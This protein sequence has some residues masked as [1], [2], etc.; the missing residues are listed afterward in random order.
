MQS[1]PQFTPSS[2]QGT[3]AVLITSQLNPI[4]SITLVMPTQFSVSSSP[5]YI[6]GTLSVAWTP[7]S[8]NT[9][10]AG[11]TSGGGAAPA[12]RSLVS[13]DLP[14]SGTV[15]S[16]NLSMPGIFSVSGN[17]VIGSGTIAVVL[18][19]QSA[20]VVFSGP[21]SGGS[22]TPT[23]R[24]LVAADIPSLSFLTNV[25]GTPPSITSSVV[26]GVA[27]L[28]IGQPV[29][30]SNSPTFA[31]VTITGTS[32][33]AGTGSFG[34]VHIPGTGAYAVTGAHVGQSGSIS[35]GSIT[36]IFVESGIIWSWS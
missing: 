16:I 28:S 33:Y 35:L 34:P 7:E 13:A 25:A 18:A 6:S 26:G 21:S 19:A 15:T 31:S 1:T 5:L 14:G 30:T 10:L 8:A 9:V 20:H 2:T 29:G 23:F 27:T 24:A 3:L 17:P 4:A 36:Q 11:P 22:T 32:F 12:F